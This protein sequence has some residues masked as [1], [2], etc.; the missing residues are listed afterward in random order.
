LRPDQ[1][2]GTARPVVFTV[3]WAS[4]RG[5]SHPHWRRRRA[6]C[7]HLHRRTARD[8]RHSDRAGG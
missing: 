4:L 2:R 1:P 8:G 5:R 3:L 7:R 6:V